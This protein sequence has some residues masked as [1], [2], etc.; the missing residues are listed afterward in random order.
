M[1]SSGPK[2][3]N[4]MS[5]ATKLT[6]GETGLVTKL[7]PTL[8]C[9]LFLHYVIFQWLVARITCNEHC[10]LKSIMD[11][12]PSCDFGKDTLSLNLLN[13]DSI[14]LTSKKVL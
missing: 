11:L 14:E 3:L 13:K 10:S 12:F 1:F 8:E 7:H 4:N 6:G 5:N 9:R 2:R